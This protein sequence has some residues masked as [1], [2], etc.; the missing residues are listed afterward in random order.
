MKNAYLTFA[1][2]ISENIMYSAKIGDSKECV[3]CL[4]SVHA[5]LCYESINISHSSRLFF[6]KNSESCLDSY[7]LYDCSGCS[8]CFGCANLKNK[9]YFIFNETVRLY[10]IR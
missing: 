1:A 9:S 2:W 3:D 4:S 8:N 7:F 5:D 10:N 6:S